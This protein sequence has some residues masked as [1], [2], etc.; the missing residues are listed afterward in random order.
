MKLIAPRVDRIKPSPSS[1]AGQ[2]AR[3][4][5]AAGRDIVSL[6]T[7]EPDFD[8]P[9]NVCEAAVR[10]MTASKTKYTDVGGTPE[11]KAAI[12]A[13]LR[14]DNGLEYATAEIVVGAGAKQIIFNALM[15][16]VDRGDEVIVPTPYWVSYP[17]IVLLADGT[18]VFAPCPPGKGFKLQ[19]EDLERAITPRTKWLILNAPNNPSG[20]AYTREEMKALT[21]VLMRHPHVWVMSDDIYEHLLY[22]GREFVTPAQVEPGLKERTLTINGVSKAYAM[23]G[24]RIG[25]GAA[26]APLIKAMVKLQSQS[27]TNPSS[28]GQAAAAE[29]LNGPQAVIA[30]RT[31]IFQKRRD[32]VV[33]LLNEIPGI[34]CHRPEG[35]FYVFPSCAGTIGRTTP[36]GKTIAGDEDFVLYLLEA[37][38]LAVLHGAAYGVSPFFRIS[39]A[40]SMETLSEGCQ[41]LRRACEALR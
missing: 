28:I 14:R 21:E 34:E 2:R 35:A 12:Q 3:E 8:T 20:A 10:A 26:P 39:Y 15:A 19:P 38:N 33:E 27:T 25:Y 41:R 1:M 24:W 11:I 18:P 4:L 13:K 30:E 23:T 16:T 31:A 22:D 6:T 32:K 9:A 17:D 5:R 29:A 40:A 36:A 37:E 7:G